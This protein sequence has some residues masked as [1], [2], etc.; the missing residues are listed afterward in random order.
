MK[1]LL[2][3]FLSIVLPAI[4]FAETYICSSEHSAS[5]GPLINYL[6]SKE[7][8][9]LFDWVVDTE[10]GI[11]PL[12]PTSEYRGSCELSGTLVICVSGNDKYAENLVLSEENLV[13]TRSSTVFGDSVSSEQGN[14]T[15]L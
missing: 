8:V 4:S 1:I 3:L 10:L 9:E 15:K 12:T 5:L 14:C 13:F 6:Q 11:R 2:V 7:E